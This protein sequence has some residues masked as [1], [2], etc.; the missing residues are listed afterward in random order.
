MTGCFCFRVLALIV[1]IKVGET[2]L[3]DR[4]RCFCRGDRVGGV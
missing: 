1:G 3:C 4:V 2:V